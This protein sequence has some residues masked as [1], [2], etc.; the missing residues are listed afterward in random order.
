[1]YKLKKV[2]P[3]VRL[4]PA[5]SVT[6]TTNGFI[7]NK[8]EVVTHFVFSQ[9]KRWLIEFLFEPLHF[10]LFFNRLLTVAMQ[11]CSTQTLDVD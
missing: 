11:Y 3:W 9:S 2:L 10:K 6:N 4:K 8:L 7:L 1:M 5:K